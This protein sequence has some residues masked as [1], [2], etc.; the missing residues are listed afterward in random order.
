MLVSGVHTIAIEPLDETV[1]RLATS[2]VLNKLE[3]KVTLVTHPVSNANDDCL[4]F[5]KIPQGEKTLKA[6]ST[7]V[8]KIMV[9]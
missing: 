9:S 7:I 6:Y 4:N 2:I 3:D 5:V 1:K 8:K